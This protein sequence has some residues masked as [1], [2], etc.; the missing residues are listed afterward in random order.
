[1][2]ILFNRNNSIGTLC[3]LLLLAAVAGACVKDEYAEKEKA[4]VTMTFTTRAESTPQYSSSLLDNEQMKTLRVIVARHDDE[5]GESGDILYNV[6]YNIEPQETS[7]TITFSE[8]TINKSGESF[9]FYAIAN[10]EGIITTLD[11]ENLT[12]I[13]LKNWSL[14]CPVI[15]AIDTKSIPQTAFKTILVKPTED[16]SIQR[17]NMQLE[18]VVAK[19]S[20]SFSNETGK[21]QILSDVK[22]AGAKPD[23]GFLFNDE[24]ND[25]T[26]YIPT[27]VNYSGI[28][29]S[30]TKISTGTETDPE[31]YDYP[32]VYLF[33]GQ[34]PSLNNG[35][36]LTAMLNESDSRELEMSSIT[37]L[38]R[39]QELK[40]NIRL[41]K[42]AVDTHIDLI[43]E[44]VDWQKSSNTVPSFN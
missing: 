27:D 22:I 43:W 12:S 36:I 31:V 42:K 11:F 38:D 40:I 20:L 7:K 32:P 18:F 17:E 6:K 34:N 35:Y 2:K 13:D 1:M 19:V 29:W 14:N 5:T 21:A 30:R 44:V 24:D 15:A 26:I 8:L 9:D 23:K 25:G 41:Y 4:T 3:L 37:G 16:G 33:P 10:E 28:I 39:G